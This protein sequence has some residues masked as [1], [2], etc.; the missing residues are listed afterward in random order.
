MSCQK[1]DSPNSNLAANANIAKAASPASTT[2]PS[3]S[4]PE[5]AGAY[6]L[7]SPSDTYRAANEA[8]KKCD[9]PMLKRI[10]S[11][12]LTDAMTQRGES[13]AGGRKTLDDMLKDLCALPQSPNGDNIK[14][15]KTVGDEGTVKYQDENGDWQL[16][17]FV[18][19]NG[20]WKLTMPR[21]KSEL[22]A[23]K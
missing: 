15:E 5:T 18:R 17:D 10:M 3:T 4:V 9:M 19:E 22:P 2:N 1:A 12:E 13:E 20:E 21:G 11:Q 16:M 23:L 6:S 14:D 8:R 7:A